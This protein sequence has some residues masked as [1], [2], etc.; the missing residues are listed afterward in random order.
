MGG[1]LPFPPAMALLTA[2]SEGLFELGS[3]NG[4]GHFAALAG[5][6]APPCRVQCHLVCGIIV[7]EHRFSFKSSNA[8]TRSD[9]TPER[10]VVPSPPEAAALLRAPGRV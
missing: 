9:Y 5:Q 10:R 8:N 2:L 4:K 3:D 1:A 7:L 6:Q